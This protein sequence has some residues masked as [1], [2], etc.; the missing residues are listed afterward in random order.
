MVFSKMLTAV[1]LATCSTQQVALVLKAARTSS[2]AE[3]F[4]A[5]ESYPEVV[6]KLSFKKKSMRKNIIKVRVAS[7]RGVTP[8]EISGL[9]KD[10]PD[11]R[12]RAALAKSISQ[13]ISDHNTPPKTWRVQ[14]DSTMPVMYW[15]VTNPTS[16]CDE[17]HTDYIGE[18]VYHTGDRYEG[19]FQNVPKHGQDGYAALEDDDGKGWNGLRHGQGTFTWAADGNTYEG[20]WKLNQRDGRGK[21]TSANG[22]S[23]DGEFVKNERH[24]RGKFTWAADGNTYDGFWNSNN[25]EGEGVLT[26]KDGDCYTGN[27][28]GGKKHGKGTYKHADGSSREEY[29]EDGELISQDAH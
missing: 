27:W 29:W 4:R 21:E 3:A 22:D 19:E 24:G 1:A 18:H 8:G 9:R 25:W 2:P 23:Y 15:G 13:L 7:G 11:P 14:T 17:H 6:L 26:Y 10:I 5:S 12:S 28:K 16:G 20:E